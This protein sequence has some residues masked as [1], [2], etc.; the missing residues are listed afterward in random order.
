MITLGLA[1]GS[2]LLVRFLILGILLRRL[3]PKKNKSLNAIVRARI[4]HL[5]TLLVP[6]WVIWAVLP[7]YSPE[8]ANV[9]ISVLSQLL[10]IYVAVVITLVLN[11]CLLAINYYY[12]TLDYSKTFPINSILD[13]ARVVLFVLSAVI[14]IS[15]LFNI[16]SIYILT[17]IGALIAAGTVVFNN[18]ILALVSGL[19]LTSK[20]L[21]VI[22][23]WI[24]IP[25][26]RINGEVLEITLTTVI[27]RNL[28]HTIGTVP[29]AYL[30][31]NS[32]K[33]WRGVLEAGARQIFWPVYFDINSV[34]PAGPELLE[35]ITR[36]PYGAEILRSKAVV[37]AHGNPYRIPS[38]APSGG[39]NLA[40]FREYCS[41]YLQNHPLVTTQ[42]LL[43]VYLEAPTEFGIPMRIMVS[44]RETDYLR[45]LEIQS[46]LLGEILRLA[47]VFGLKVYQHFDRLD[48]ILSSVKE[49]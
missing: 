18:L 31:A 19:I 48:P 13:V 5:L 36:L 41:L 16:P 22:G 49:Q 38:G 40:L 44:I 15:I 3:D 9:A 42:K 30:L 46:D 20:R 24:E 27:V 21:I 28:D 33:N 45:F 47:N 17:A 29:S 6:P 10:T 11:A 1:A 39:T 25:E 4:P 34:K 7:Y 12:N 43:S 32:F 37:E 2:Y 35:D 23:D 26:L 14:L 8:S